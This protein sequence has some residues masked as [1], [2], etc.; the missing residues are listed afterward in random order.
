MQPAEVIESHEP[1]QAR[2]WFDPPQ[3]AVHLEEV[4]D[5]AFGFQRQA[6]R[7]P[8]LGK[9][10]PRPPVLPQAGKSPGREKGPARPLPTFNRAP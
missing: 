6:Q 10:P 2:G 9:L 4:L 8:R 7:L 3:V 1:H 5:S